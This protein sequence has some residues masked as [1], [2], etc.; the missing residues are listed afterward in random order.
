MSQEKVDYKKQKKSGRK[1]EV[2]KERMIRRLWAVCA[3][4]IC[5]GLVGFIGYS[6][7]GVIEENRMA[8]A[9]ENMKTTDIDISAIRDYQNSLSA[10]ED[11]AE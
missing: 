6:L 11:D 4:V 1:E 7:Y 5:V 3:V 8:A 10:D 2:K 9:I